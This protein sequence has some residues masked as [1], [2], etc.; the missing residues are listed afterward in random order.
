MPVKSSTAL[1]LVL[2]FFFND[3]ATTEIY[4]LSLHDALPISDV[5]R[6]RELA[7]SGGE[8]RRVGHDT[9]SPDEQQRGQRHERRSKEKTNDAR[10]A[11]G[12]DHRGAGHECAAPAIGVLPAQPA[13]DGAAADY[14]ERHKRRESRD[15]GIRT[16]ARVL[17]GGVE[18]RHPGPHSRP[19]PT[20][21]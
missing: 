13:S 9:D 2:F 5:V 15:V 14:R 20:S 3:T 7:D 6:G 12:D 1:P 16:A 21:T 11:A 17:A 19:P 8:L 10:T 18:Y 4:T